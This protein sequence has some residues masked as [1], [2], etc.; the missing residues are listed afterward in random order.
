MWE[1]TYQWFLYLWIW[2]PGSV[3]PPGM[4]WAKFGP[5][6]SLWRQEVLCSSCLCRLFWGLWKQC[7]ASER[8]PEVL[9][10]TSGASEWLQMWPEQDFGCIWSSSGSEN[11]GFH[12]LRFSVSLGGRW[13]LGMDLCGSQGLTVLCA[14]TTYAKLLFLS[15]VLVYVCWM[16]SNILSLYGPRT[17]RE[18]GSTHCWWGRQAQAHSFQQKSQIRSKYFM[19]WKSRLWY[20]DVGASEQQNW[21]EYIL[22]V[23]IHSSYI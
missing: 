17:N 1:L 18:A 15:A 21:I 16:Y 13:G 22:I 9:A 5:I 23:L 4:C 7:E 10:G 6:W 20:F 11:H 2:F 19:I 3:G 14:H 12:Y 8:L